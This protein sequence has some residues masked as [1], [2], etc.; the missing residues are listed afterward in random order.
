MGED[1]QGSHRPSV[2]NIGELLRRP[3]RYPNGHAAARVPSC[4][5]SV[6]IR[7]NRRETA[8]P[9]G[10]SRAIGP[11]GDRGGEVLDEPP[12]DTESGERADDQGNPE[13]CRKSHPTLASHWR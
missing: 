4:Q 6:G 11:G 1:P 10:E 2:T 7:R 3:M 5:K 8:W 12:R 9:G 13:E